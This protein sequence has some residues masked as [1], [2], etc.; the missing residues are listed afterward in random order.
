MHDG[1]KSRITVE[2]LFSVL[3]NSVFR[4]LL[5]PKITHPKSTSAKPAGSTA[6]VDVANGA[7]YQEY[8]SHKCFHSSYIIVYGAF[9]HRER[10]P[11][12]S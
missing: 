10:Q 2:E 9:H 12:G 3:K 7:A 1:A 8:I 4:R 11:T 6:N 5:I